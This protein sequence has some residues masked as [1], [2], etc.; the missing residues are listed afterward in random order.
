MVGV[1]AP[2]WRG[3]DAMA[4]RRG[5]HSIGA[6]HKASMRRR[7]WSRVMLSQVYGI[8]TAPDVFFHMDVKASPSMSRNITITKSRSIA[9]SSHLAVTL[10]DSVYRLCLRTTPAHSIEIALT[11]VIYVCSSLYCSYVSSVTGYLES[12]TISKS[13]PL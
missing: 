11:E 2:H 12:L 1:C 5:A 13:H 7:L 9:Y 10:L 4:S 8:K 6:P 3:R